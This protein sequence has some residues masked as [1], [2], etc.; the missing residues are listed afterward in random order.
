[1]TGAPHGAPI[2]LKNTVRCD[3]MEAPRIE[4]RKGGADRWTLQRTIP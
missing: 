3:I 1:M 4:F 2:L